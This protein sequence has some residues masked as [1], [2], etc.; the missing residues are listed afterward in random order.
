MKIPPNYGSDFVNN[1]GM[2]PAAAS[3]SRE[4]QAP[5]DV[6]KQAGAGQPRNDKINLS[7]RAKDLQKVHEVLK[8]TPDVREEK[9]QALKA[10]ID[11]GT[12]QVRSKDV[13][14]KMVNQHLGNLLFNA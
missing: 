8:Q 9:V 5:S 13:A 10:K 1:A 14:E 2:N 4:S 12:Y 7:S 11:N 6:S 3:K